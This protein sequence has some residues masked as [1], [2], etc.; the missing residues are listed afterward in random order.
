MR[1]LHVSDAV[2]SE[3]GRAGGHQVRLLLR[4][5][6]LLLRLR[7]LLLLLLPRLLLHPR[8]LPLLLLLPRLLELLV[9]AQCQLRRHL[10]RCGGHQR[11]LWPL[12]LGDVHCRGGIHGF[13]V[14]LQHPLLGHTLGNHLSRP[15]LDLWDGARLPR[16]LGLRN[17]Q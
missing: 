4:T 10:D 17:R 15:S 5:L 3:P 6:P 2:P 8:L 9:G 14:G 7:R 12:P 1:L 13:P 11:R 16:S